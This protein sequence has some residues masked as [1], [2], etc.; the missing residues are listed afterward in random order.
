MTWLTPIRISRLAV[1]IILASVGS[2]FF[3]AGF[4]YFYE[5]PHNKGISTEDFWNAGVDWVFD[6]FFQT[7]KIFNT[8]L[9]VDVLQPMRAVYLRMPIVATFVL[10]MAQVILSVV[11]AQHL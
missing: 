6:T 10:V 2:L 9:I 8:W 7:L 3:K 1:G 11:F 5:V 4:N